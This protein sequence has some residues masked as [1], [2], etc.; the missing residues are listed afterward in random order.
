MEL[1][2]EEEKLERGWGSRRELSKL[3]YLDECAYPRINPRFHRLLGALKSRSLSRVLFLVA[4]RWCGAIIYQGIENVHSSK[5]SLVSKGCA[6]PRS[7]LIEI[8][9]VST[10]CTRMEVNPPVSEVTRDME[11]SQVIRGVAGYRST[12]SKAGGIPKNMQKVKYP[13]ITPLSH[14]DPH[15]THRGPMIVEHRRGVPRHRR[16][17]EGA[18]SSEDVGV[19]ELMECIIC[20]AGS[21]L[22]DHNT[23][24]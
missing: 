22:P 4:L 1:T 6:R 7:F 21:H 14:Q 18:A 19:S 15:K 17:A 23:L 12:A 10:K 16:F 24:E 20:F 11:V 3:L 8:D 5:R 13:T 2:R 9:D